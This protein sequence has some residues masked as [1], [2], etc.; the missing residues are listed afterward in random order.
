MADQTPLTSS[1]IDQLVAEY[2]DL[3]RDYLGYLRNF[4][5][6]QTPRGHMLYSGPIAPDEVYPQLEGDRQRILIGD[7]MAGYC[8]GYDFSSKKYGEYND[9]GEWSTF[10]GDFNLAAHLSN[11]G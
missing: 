5:W 3:P 2:P 4:G 7:D 6:G 1:E 8:L 10:D 11:A 9:F